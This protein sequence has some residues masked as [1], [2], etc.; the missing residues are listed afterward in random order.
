[1]TMACD[2]LLLKLK[3]KE[4][5]SKRNKIHKNEINLYKIRIKSRGLVLYHNMPCIFL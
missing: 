4:N 3:V 2:L 5:K 1:M